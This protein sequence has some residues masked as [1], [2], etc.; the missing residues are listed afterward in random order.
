ML[1]DINISI[2]LFNKIQQCCVTTTHLTTLVQLKL[3]FPPKKRLILP[4][5]LGSINKRYLHR[6]DHSLMPG[7]D[8][9][10]LFISRHPRQ[11]DTA[12]SEIPPDKHSSC[13]DTYL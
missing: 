4:L 2:C 6:V 1:I 8:V 7:G 9:T 5:N 11:E 12:S 10:H 13:F 3:H